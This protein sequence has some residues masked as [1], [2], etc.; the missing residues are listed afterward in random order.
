MSASTRTGLLHCS[1]DVHRVSDPAAVR[2]LLRAVC[3]VDA[4]PSSANLSQ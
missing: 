2:A 4:N 1:N 3:A